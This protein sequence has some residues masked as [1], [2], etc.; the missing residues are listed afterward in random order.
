M[1]VQ[2][3]AASA[4][5]LALLLP[6]AAL[7]GQ[8]KP[9]PPPAAPAPSATPAPAAPARPKITLKW[10]TAS[11]V[12]NYGFFVFRGDDEKGPFKALNERILPG[13]GNSDVPSNYLYEDLDV[14]PGRA[15][16]YYLESVSTQGVHEKFSPVLRKDCCKGFE[17]A[18][19]APAPEGTPAP[20]PSPTPA[21]PRT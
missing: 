14:V 5:C 13:A 3:R 21:P 7:A 16:Y 20:K 19:K 8:A 11:E 17:A 12:D 4:F 15:Y 18:P 9:A 1:P 2:T 10:S 6:A